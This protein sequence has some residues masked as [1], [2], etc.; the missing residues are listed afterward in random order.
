LPVVTD[1]QLGSNG[2]KSSETPDLIIPVMTDE[3]IIQRIAAGGPSDHHH[4]LQH[5]YNRWGPAMKHYFIRKGC[6][7]KDADDLFQDSV[8]KIW[9]AAGQFKASGPATS[10]VWTIARNTLNDHLRK[11][12]RLPESEP[13]N[14]DEGDAII[15]APNI[16]DAEAE[17][18]D[19]VSEGLKRFAQQDPDRAYALELWTA[20]LDLREIADRIGRSYGATRQYLMECRKKLR[21]LLEPCLQYLEP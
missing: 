10:W 17:A 9:S 16:Y 18:D 3:E 4:A 21:P 19:C 5:I 7:I 13:L 20:D 1:W 8:V 12:L 15:I 14:G 2:H 11:A 6:S